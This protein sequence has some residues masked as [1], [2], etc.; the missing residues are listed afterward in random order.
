M[1]KSGGLEDQPA[2]FIKRIEIIENV[3]NSFYSMKHAK[4]AAEWANSQ[5][6]AFGIVANVHKMRKNN[7]E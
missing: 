1:L 3:Y 2:G 4:S 7:G 6:Q 5:P